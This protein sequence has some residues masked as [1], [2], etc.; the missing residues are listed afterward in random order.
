ML[1]NLSE[2][3]LKFLCKIKFTIYLPPRSNPDNKVYTMP[4]LNLPK[5]PF[6]KK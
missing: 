3:T 5:F 4:K 2:K 6:I 1:T